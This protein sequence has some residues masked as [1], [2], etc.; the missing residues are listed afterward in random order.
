LLDARFGGFA[1][2]VHLF[3]YT[4]LP[5]LPSL[6]TARLP[7]TFQGGDVDALLTRLGNLVEEALGSPSVEAADFEGLE[8]LVAA[9]RQVASLQPDGTRQ[10]VLRC[11]GIAALLQ[12]MLEHGNVARQGGLD[13]EPGSAGS[14]GGGSASAASGPLSPEAEAYAQHVLRLVRRKLAELRTLVP[15]R[16]SDA[17][18]GVLRGAVTAMLAGRTAG[19]CG[20]HLY[21][22]IEWH[23]GWHRSCSAHLL[24]RHPQLQSL[25]FLPGCTARCC[26][27]GASTPRA[28]GSMSIDDYEILKPISRGAFGRVYLARECGA[29]SMCAFYA[30][31]S[32]LCLTAC[33][34]CCA[35]GHA[36]QQ[37]W[38]RTLLL[39]CI[40]VHTAPC[41]AWA[42]SEATRHH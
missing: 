36:P 20:L 35:T 29:G 12:A 1:A 33:C 24:G 41:G 5:A 25:S 2:A 17:E 21:L 31:C 26:P 16:M 7:S 14:A 8:D 3:S 40:P 38:P 11:E 19:L 15:G 42:L 37:H 32:V 28:A 13:P 6:P 22:H 4:P 34:A 30:L 10:P 39:A 18:S 27:A 23:A 9:C